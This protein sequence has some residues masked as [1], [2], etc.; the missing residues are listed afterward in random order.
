MGAFGLLPQDWIFFKCR[1]VQISSSSEKMCQDDANT[2]TE[3]TAQSD[4]YN[5]AD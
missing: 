5:I 4:A 2:I 3:M 1:N